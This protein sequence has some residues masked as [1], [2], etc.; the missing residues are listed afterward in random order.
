MKNLRHIVSSDQ[1][2]RQDMEELFESANKMESL[3]LKQG[4]TDSAAGKVMT[5]LFYQPSTRT[6]L[7]FETAMVRLGGRYVSTENALEFSSHAKGESLE[8]TIQVVAA[9]ADVVVLRYHK[10]GGAERAASVSPVPLINAGDGPGQHPTQALLDTY[11]IHKEFGGI[12]GLEIALVGD[13]RFGRTVHSLVYLLSQ[14]T[15]GR[16]NLVSPPNTRMPEHYLQALSARGVKVLEFSDLR[17]VAERVDVIYSTRLQK[18]YFE[19]EDDYNSAKGLYVLSDELRSSLKNS[20]IIMHPLPRLEEI[21]YAVDADPR[22]RYFHQVKNG[23]YMRMA[24]LDTI[25]NG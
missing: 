18:E 24:L 14:Y 13:L 16:I 7:S 10:E 22:A 8:D 12:D 21:P 2:Q 4:C 20:A 19:N 3:V 9:Y 1:F 6:R 11:T 23:L 15:I 5:V 17:E 25:F